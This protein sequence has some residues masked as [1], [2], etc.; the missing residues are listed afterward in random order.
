MSDNVIDEIM[1]KNK[2]KPWT[3]FVGI[4]V[5]LIILIGLHAIVLAVPILGLIYVVWFGI[6]I[7][8]FVRGKMKQEADR[9]VAI[10]AARNPLT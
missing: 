1:T 7:I 6:N 3:T 9:E 8:N 5:F 10:Q 2:N 4:L